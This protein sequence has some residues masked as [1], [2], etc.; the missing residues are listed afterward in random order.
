MTLHMFRNIIW[1]VGKFLQ[2]TGLV[3]APYALYVGMS[4]SDAR[5]ELKLLLL[6]VIQFLLGLLMVKWSSK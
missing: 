5:S 1:H 4:T 3:V 2:L 6:A